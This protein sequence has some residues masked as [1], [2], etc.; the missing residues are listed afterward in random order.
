MNTTERLIACGNW[1]TNH[2]PISDSYLKKA[3]A[4]LKLDTTK[5]TWAPLESIFNYLNQSRTTSTY[6]NHLE[7]ISSKFNG[8]LTE[9]K[10]TATEL[11]SF[12]S[13]FEHSFKK[14]LATKP[15]S[16]QLL[17][18]YESE[19]SFIALETTDNITDISAYQLIKTC[20]ALADI[21]ATNLSATETKP[22][23][24]VALDVSGIQ[25]YIYGINTSKALVGLRARSLYLDLMVEVLLTDLLTNLAYS[26]A[27]LLY[28]GGG[29]AYLLVDNRQATQ[30]FLKEFEAKTN[31]WFV[32]NF[33]IQLYI[34]IASVACDNDDL[35]GNNY[36]R[37][38]SLFTNITKAL[39]K[40][41]LHRYS[42]KQLA[43]LNQFK[44]SVNYQAGRECSV[45]RRSDTNLT[46]VDERD[47]CTICLALERFGNTKNLAANLFYVTK[48]KL[49]N[50]L[51]MPN[52]YYLSL[53]VPT[54]FSFILYTGDYQPTL[55]GVHFFNGNYF[56]K[57]A[58]NEVKELTELAQASQG[59][60][61]LGVLR[62]DID[63]L[64]TAFVQGFK[65]KLAAQL[66][67]HR[68]TLERIAMLSFELS[69]FFKKN[70][71]YLLNH[72]KHYLPGVSRTG[73]REAM[74]IYSG[75]DDVF[76]VGAWDEMV[77]LALD[78][79]DH[80]SSYTNHRLNISAG[81]GLFNAHYPLA[82][83][84]ELTGD[85]EDYAKSVVNQDGVQTKNRLALF[86]PKFTVAWDEL[87]TATATNNVQAKM[88]TLQAL[89][90]EQTN[91]SSGDNTSL[92]YKLLTYFRNVKNDKINIARLA[93]TIGRL[94]LSEKLK[95]DLG[96]KL[97]QWIETGPNQLQTELAIVLLV[98]LNRE[99]TSSQLPLTKVRGL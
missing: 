54:E 71:N 93:Y 35:H 82:A 20:V 85:L 73:G 98:Y 55:D 10:Y 24:L 23:R 4:Y 68:P 8:S 60:K 27:N 69:L 87:L 34:A 89:L 22:F 44:H 75:G 45:C 86:E 32:E 26:R 57:T 6:Y 80:L 18:F 81:I 9:T 90:A 53:K 84:A 66:N 7:R 14:L 33:N 48:T 96:L 19:L 63:N 29:R 77:G 3:L 17:N 51:P 43:D 11:S 15:T 59:I 65:P 42:A 70:I 99:V 21:L 39:S 94:N 31:Q 92:L 47:L 72:P 12:L 1:L 40:R 88:A 30:D 95:N 46:T 28:V 58:A 50:S 97:L 67:P 78:I 52:N 2:T 37:Y 41:K 91:T 74:I 25:A 49:P 64:G 56:A 16:R 61:R 62:C 79:K 38:R 5:P 76:I 83:M 13:D 36:E